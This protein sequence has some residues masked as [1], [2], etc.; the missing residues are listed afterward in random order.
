MSIYTKLAWRNI[1]RNTRRSLIAGSAIGMGL[2]AMM[3]ADSVIKGMEASLLHSATDSFM[4]E[5]QIHG[6]GF[7]ESF[8]VER[9]I[10]DIARVETLLAGDSLIAHSAPRLLALSMISSP[11]NL[12]TVTLAGIDPEREIFLSEVDN[13]IIEGSFLSVGTSNELL[14]GDKLA[15]LLEV[16]LGDRI[17]LT[18]AQAE[19]GDL[20][21]ELFRVSGI[22]HLGVDQ[23]D[24]GTCFINLNRAQTMLGLEG[25]V[26]QMA[27]KF[28]N[29]SYGGSTDDAFWQRYATPDNEIAGWKVLLPELAAAFTL[30]TVQTAIMGIILFGIVSL[31]IANTLFM[32]LYD[33][34]FEF[35]VLRAVGTRPFAMGKLIVLEAGSLA[36]IGTTMGLLLGS[37][38]IYIFSLTG[39]DY[40][41]VEFAG[42]TIR[43]QLFP[44]IRTEQFTL[45][46][47]IV[48]ALT[49]LVG[50]YPGWYAARLIPAEAMR[51]AL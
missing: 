24:R 38:V 17:V 26:H 5:A 36:V 3:F 22:F 1:F 50:L 33:R 42:A 21:Q 12:T 18:A 4:G 49:T 34:L 46:P 48:L 35:G 28:T 6:D 2:A 19:T 41:G 45:Y 16:S 37:L 23:L 40:G 11:A 44:V 43:G 20:A 32:S 15:D 7:R 14:I 31:G 13:T 30:I 29:P 51:K 9:T 10:S 8:E 25:R 27:L 47:A 39:I